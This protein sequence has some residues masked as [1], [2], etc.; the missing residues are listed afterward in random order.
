MAIRLQS[1]YFTNFTSTSLL[2][3]SC[4]LHP[5]TS[6][7]VCIQ[8]GESLEGWPWYRL[9]SPGWASIHG[10]C[11]EIGSP[12]G[13]SLASRIAL[14][15]TVEIWKHAILLTLRTRTAL[16]MQGPQEQHVSRETLIN[17]W[18]ARLV[19]G[20]QR[21]TQ[22][23]KWSIIC[24]PRCL[25]NP[26]RMLPCS[27]TVALAPPFHFPQAFGFINARRGRGGQNTRAAKTIRRNGFG[28]RPD[29]GPS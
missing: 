21:L 3:S 16:H 8:S 5:S 4:F 27:A 20:S 10:S 1:S 29:N 24:Q 12:E 23:V 19:S 25:W 2:S 14:G 17:H 13:L 11:S 6:T 7:T 28:A 15:C 9:L 26:S 18:T 22:V